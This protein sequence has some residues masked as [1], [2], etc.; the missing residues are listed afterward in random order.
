MRQSE[1]EVT[2]LSVN[3][4]SQYYVE[5]ILYIFIYIIYIIYLFIYYT[6]NRKIYII[7]NI[8]YNILYRKI[9]EKLARSQGQLATVA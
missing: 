4:S 7:Y 5:N 9:S 6:L 1:L 8:I 2:P 3:Y